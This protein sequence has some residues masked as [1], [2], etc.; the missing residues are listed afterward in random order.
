MIEYN[1]MTTFHFLVEHEFDK[2]EPV[3]KYCTAQYPSPP[4]IMSTI[5][6]GIDVPISGAIQEIKVLR[7]TVASLSNTI[8]I[9]C[10]DC[11]FI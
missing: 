3:R 6:S 2:I 10:V 9:R 8:I 7:H 11:Y 4:L 5:E 1:A